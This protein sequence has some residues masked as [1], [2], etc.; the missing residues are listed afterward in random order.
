MDA[1]SSTISAIINAQRQGYREVVFKTV[2]GAGSFKVRNLLQRLQREGYIEAVSLIAGSAINK[3][4]IVLYKVRLKY[5]SR[6]KPAVQSFFRI[7][8]P[9]RRIFTK[10]G[11]F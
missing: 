4:K 2:Q 10:S 9:S 7:S 5:N 8:S 1:F 6:G 3:K 11:S